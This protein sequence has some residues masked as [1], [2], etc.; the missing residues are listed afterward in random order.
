MEVRKE[1]WGKSREG[2][3]DKGKEEEKKKGTVIGTYQKKLS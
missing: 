2:R 3:K 1:D